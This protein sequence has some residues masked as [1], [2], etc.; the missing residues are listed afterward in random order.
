MIAMTAVNM[1]KKNRVMIQLV[2]ESIGKYSKV[3]EKILD[4]SICFIKVEY[5]KYFYKVQWF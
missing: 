4:G 1:I 2:L 3:L 5:L